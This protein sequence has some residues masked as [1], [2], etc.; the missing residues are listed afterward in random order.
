[1]N[2]VL[3]KISLLS[4]GNKQISTGTTNSEGSNFYRNA[5]EAK[6]VYM[7]TDTTICQFPTSVCCNMPNLLHINVMR[8]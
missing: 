1:M 7:R 5:K 6:N 8:L 2:K 4:H 3:C